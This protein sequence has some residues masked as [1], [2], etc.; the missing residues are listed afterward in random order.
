MAQPVDVAKLAA[1]VKDFLRPLASQAG[2]GE[3]AQ[4]LDNLC[5]V[6]VVF[7]IFRTRLGIKE[8]ISCDEFENLHGLALSRCRV[9]Q[10]NAQRTMAAILQTSVLAPHLAPRIT[11]GDL[12]CLVWISSVKWWFTQQALPKSAILTLIISEA[13]ASSAL[14]FS[15]VVADGVDLSSDML[16][17]SRVSI[18]LR[19]LASEFVGTLFRSTYAVFSAC[20]FDSS[21]DLGDDSFF[22]ASI[23]VS[24]CGCS[25]FWKPGGL[26]V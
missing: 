21:A 12:Y 26:T 6:V 3:R 18:S 19:V 23:P 4:K 7:S 24:N 16:E 11:S 5:N 22:L 2:T 9:Q 14:R 15:P 17:T 10:D 1:A 20:D 13:W 25:C 8:V